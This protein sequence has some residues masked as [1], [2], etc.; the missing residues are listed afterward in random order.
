MS[1]QKPN[2][3]R[4]VRR[5]DVAPP[6]ASRQ[7]RSA[8]NAEREQKDGTALTMEERKALLR[9]EWSDDILP[10]IVDGN[11]AYHYCW[12]STTNQTDPI[13]RRLRLGYELVRYDELPYLGAQNRMES[14]EFAGCISINE[15]ILAKI[16]NELYQELMLI[17]HY[18][19][20]MQEE[21]LL[22]ANIEKDE[23]DSSGKKLARLEGSGIKKLVKKVRHP[24]FE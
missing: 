10:Q 4:V 22:R 18:E 14:G 17:N 9:Q 16:P 12:L 7:D 6:V 13:Y 3:E 20:P 15:M 21:E 11:P 23:E 24:H 5:T 1:E 8:E 19:K 2:D